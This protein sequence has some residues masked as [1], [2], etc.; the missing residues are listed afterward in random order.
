L[1]TIFVEKLPNLTFIE[2]YK[3]VRC[4]VTRNQEKIFAI[5]EFSSEKEAEIC[6]NSMNKKEIDGITFHVEF[7]LENQNTKETK[8]TP[9][10]EKQTKQTYVNEKPKQTQ[11][12][13]KPKLSAPIMNKELKETI[14]PV[15]ESSPKKISNE[16]KK[17][18]NEKNSNQGQSNNSSKEINPRNDSKS[19][20][21]RINGRRD[22]R[23]KDKRDSRRDMDY[24]RDSKD[25]DHRRDSRDYRRDSRKDYDFREEPRNKNYKPE[26]KSFQ[27]SELFSEPKRSYSPPKSKQPTQET[28]YTSMA[29]S[30]FKKT[31]P[32]P[33]LGNWGKP[34]TVIEL[35][36]SEDES[37]SKFFDQIMMGSKEEIKVQPM[38][39]FIKESED[40][41]FY[42][43]A[44]AFKSKENYEKIKN[45]LPKKKEMK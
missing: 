39:D 44:L 23:D 2:S 14:I 34:K 12:V 9:V 3:P 18:Q 45:L 4:K 16:E 5:L 27:R 19:R 28:N 43:L 7:I 17:I 33:N 30:M 24:K 21:Y 36:S 42:V 20:D 6:L 40:G 31:E 10:N 25:R 29:L 37:T 1:K 35:D 11:L 32:K 13:E 26:F 8:T 15:V 38:D 41:N 22:S